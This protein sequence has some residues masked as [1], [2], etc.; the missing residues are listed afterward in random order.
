MSGDREAEPDWS[1]YGCD[2]LADMASNL[3]HAKE[4]FFD[5]LEEA[6]E[7]QERREA[8]LRVPDGLTRWD[9]TIP[10]LEDPEINLIVMIEAALDVGGTYL[11]TDAID[12]ALAYV[13][14]R[15]E[16]REDGES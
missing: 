9:F 11:E 5:Q 10:T 13:L 15:R 6:L 7:E 3:W 8:A 4:K 2:E 14:A 1:T 12:R 16:G